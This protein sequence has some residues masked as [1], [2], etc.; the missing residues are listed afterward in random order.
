MPSP[1]WDQIAW[2]ANGQCYAI[3][4][5]SWRSNALG[6]VAKLQSW[7]KPL[8]RRPVWTHNKGVVGELVSVEEMLEEVGA[9]VAGVSPWHGCTHWTHLQA[10]TG[11]AVKTRL[12]LRLV[13]IWFHEGEQ[14]TPSSHA[15]VPPQWDTTWGQSWWDKLLMISLKKLNSFSTCLPIPGLY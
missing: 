13:N 15:F 5:I 1:A 7:W 10:N 2:S 9:L 11:T 3:S 14:R 8:K 4:L 6:K 12:R